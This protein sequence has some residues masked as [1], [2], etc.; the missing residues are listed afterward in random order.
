MEPRCSVS[1]S[2]AALRSPI[3]STCRFEPMRS[4]RYSSRPSSCGDG[5]L[6]F[7]I[8][9]CSTSPCRM[10]KRLWSRST[11]RSLHSAVT[12]VKLDGLPPTKYL[13]VE[14]R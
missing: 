10:R 13:E 9:I 1:A 11:P 4:S 3:G 8:A 12:S 2:T 7:I 5:A 6:G 14:S